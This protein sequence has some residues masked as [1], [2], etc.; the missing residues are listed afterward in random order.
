MTLK[1]LLERDFRVELPIS[2]GFGN[3]ND[4]AIIIHEEG[5]NDYVVT[6]GKNI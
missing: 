2:G 5:K 1:D 3:S 6:A 4:N